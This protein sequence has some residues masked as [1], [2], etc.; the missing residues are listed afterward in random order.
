MRSVLLAL[1]LA[2]CAG[3][4]DRQ[5]L[6]WYECVTRHEGQATAKLCAS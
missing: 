4:Q 1:L 3:P 2:G 6:G 5:S